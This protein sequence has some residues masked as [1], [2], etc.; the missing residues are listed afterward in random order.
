[1]LTRCVAALLLAL[2]LL[3]SNAGAT[4]TA[5]LARPDSYPLIDC[6]RGP[7]FVTVASNRTIAVNGKVVKAFALRKHL[8]EI[9]RN[10]VERLIYFE[11]DPSLQFGTVMTV[12]DKCNSIPDLR[13]ALVTTSIKNSQC[14]ILSGWHQTPR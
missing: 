6:D 7:I 1:M 8:E 12:M 4:I 5:L 10:R 13:I 2:S 9:F 14:F 11:G 3:P